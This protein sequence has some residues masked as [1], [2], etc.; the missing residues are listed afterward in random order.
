[1]SILTAVRDVAKGFKSLL[2]GM[3]ITGR[4]AVKPIVTVQYPHDTLPMPSRFRG[5]IKLI[6]DQETGTPRCTACTLCERACPTDCIVLDGVK[7]EGEK[8]KVVSKY[9]LDFTTCS[10]CGICIEVCPFD[11]IEFS[12]TYN[13]VGFS[14]DAFDNMDLY[15][16]VM[17]EAGEWAK[18]H[19]E[20]AEA[21]ANPSTD[22]AAASPDAPEGPA[23][24]DPPAGKPAAELRAES[25]DAPSG[26]P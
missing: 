21:A 18:A 15:K 9:E 12:K 2:V 8:K 16:K 20:A 11:A 14:R 23:P 3:R 4:E 1:M 24:K 19:P 10:L 17:G 5:H 7:K 26:K 13:A 25:Q 6:L 22:P